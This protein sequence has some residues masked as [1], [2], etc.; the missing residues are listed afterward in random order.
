M[1]EQNKKYLAGNIAVRRSV[2]VMCCKYG[3]Q[4]TKGSVNSHE[5][6]DPPCTTFGADLFELRWQENLLSLFFVVFLV[7]YSFVFN[8]SLAQAM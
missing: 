8:Q 4:N 7:D 5:I 6:P 2:C 3:K 1:E